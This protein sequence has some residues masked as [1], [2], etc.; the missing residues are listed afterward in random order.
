MSYEGIHVYD[1]THE[2]FTLE[3]TAEVAAADV[4]HTWGEDQL[5]WQ[6][7]IRIG[8]QAWYRTQDDP[9]WRAYDDT[10]PL[11]FVSI[12]L[13]DELE[14]LQGIADIQE[15]PDEEVRGV[16]CSRYRGGFEWEQ[17]QRATA[18][19]WIDSEDYIRQLKTTVS[20]EETDGGD[21][22]RPA[23][24]TSIMQL[25]DLNQEITINQPVI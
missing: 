11:Q 4:Y 21:S 23:T 19:L 22:E 10:V 3:G 25:Y 8:H 9:Q 7:F 24:M 14:P 20:Y 15:L 5:G 18:E 13:E 17:G 1:D 12:P 16:N 6:E 2:S